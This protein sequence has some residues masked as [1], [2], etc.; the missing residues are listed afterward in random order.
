MNKSKIL[1]LIDIGISPSFLP[2]STQECECEIVHQSRSPL[3]FRLSLALQCSLLSV[4]S[5]LVLEGAPLTLLLPNWEPTLARLPIS[6]ANRHLVY[7]EKLSEGHCFLTAWHFNRRT[8][9]SRYA[10]CRG[11]LPSRCSHPLVPGKEISTFWF[12][13]FPKEQF[14]RSLTYKRQNHFASA[15]TAQRWCFPI[16]LPFCRIYSLLSSD[17]SVI[18]KKCLPPSPLPEHREPCNTLAWVKAS[19]DISPVV[20]ADLPE[21]SGSNASVPGSYPH[22]FSQVFLLAR[23]SRCSRVNEAGLSCSHNISIESSIFPH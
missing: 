7:S 18:R 3:N 17:P 9:A 23:K 8:S 4:I 6:N 20:Y 13:F 1:I 11:S 22:R 16:L 15:E 12:K 19:R 2:S 14:F 5:P 21:G 10:Y